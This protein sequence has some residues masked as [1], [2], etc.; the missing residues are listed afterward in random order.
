MIHFKLNN[1]TTTA[2]PGQSLLQ[3]ARVN[4]IDIPAMCFY[5]GMP[6]FTSCMI[7]LMKDRQNG[8]LI[9][10]CSVK[11]TEGMDIVTDDEEIQEARRK[12]LELLL[13]DHV[14][15]CEAP[16][17]I[18]CPAHMDIPAMNR[19]L[20]EGKIGEA[21]HLVRKDIVLPSVLGRICPA[22]C[23]A[24]CR[25]KP[26]DGAVS[27]CLLKRFSG[28]FGKIE[29]SKK[30][31]V[32]DKRVAVIGAGPAGLSAAFYIRDKG[33]AC[34]LFDENELAGGMLRTAIPKEKLPHEVLDGEINLIEESGVEFRL[35]EKIDQEKFLHLQKEFDVV[36]LAIGENL[37]LLEGLGIETSE[38]GIVVDRNSYQS[39][40][41]KV[42]VVGN[43]FR[44][45][46]MAIRS[47]GQ[48]KDVAESVF[49]FLTNKEVKGPR[50]R[51]NSR[52]G[53]LMETEFSEYLKEAISDKRSEPANGISKG[54]TKAEIIQEATRCL[55]CDCRK[56]DSCKLRDYSDEYQADQKKYKYGERKTI[57]KIDQ[58]SLII[59]EPEK[60]IKCSIC[61]RLT[62]KHK[63][64]LGLT[65]IGRGF[66]VQIAVPFNEGMDRGLEKIAEEVVRACPTG[67]MAMKEI[68]IV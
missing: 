62:E 67:A 13:S 5:E 50:Q 35:S 33:V 38:K 63:E 10:S 54:F 52:F 4:G 1:K 32:S 36:V 17:K 39:N 64:K 65:F 30:E 18:A 41:P 24:V 26:I 51:F 16:C 12:S 53:K 2:K 46:K 43:A 58:H 8:K 15:E 6:H 68:K 61:V 23:E 22:P 56:L 25:R 37:K 34:T 42:F 29:I 7:C 49:Q 27:I 44:P 31:L 21:L 19:L 66:D 48:G 59:Y 47:L 40:I 14:G 20:A 55:H 28:D 9:P 60:C 3:V 57:R 45:S 11:P